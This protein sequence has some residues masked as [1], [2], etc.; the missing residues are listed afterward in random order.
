MNVLNAD[1]V[2]FKLITSA[3]YRTLR[4]RKKKKVFPKAYQ[5][6]LVKPKDPL[7]K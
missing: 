6:L 5:V 3:L 4:L 2:V 7:T 1:N